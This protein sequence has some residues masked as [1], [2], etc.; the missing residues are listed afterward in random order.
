M[1]GRDKCITLSLL[2]SGYDYGVDSIIP[3]CWLVGG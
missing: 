1:E 3:L 2:I